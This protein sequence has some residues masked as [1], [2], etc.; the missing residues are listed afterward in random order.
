MPEHPSWLVPALKTTDLLGDGDF[1]SHVADILHVHPRKKPATDVYKIVRDHFRLSW[2][3]QLAPSR[4]EKC[5]YCNDLFGGTHARTEITL[6]SG[7]KIHSSASKGKLLPL[8]W[9][10]MAVY[11]ML[12]MQGEHMW[13]SMPCFLFNT[14]M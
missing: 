5:G 8:L 12:F 6:S 7:T 11:A 13:N 4:N 2:V 3:V 14:Q 10:R 9:R 1:I